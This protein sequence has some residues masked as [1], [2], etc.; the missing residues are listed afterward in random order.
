MFIFFLSFSVHLLHLLSFSLR[1]HRAPP[2]PSR[3]ASSPSTVNLGDVPPPPRRG[4]AVPVASHDA[5]PP[6][7][8]RPS[9]PPSHPAAAAIG[10]DEEAV[11]KCV[12]LLGLISPESLKTGDFCGGDWNIGLVGAAAPPRAGGH[13]FEVG[14][15]GEVNEKGKEAPTR[16]KRPAKGASR[17]NGTVGGGGAARRAP[18]RWRDAGADEQHTM[19]MVRLT[20]VRMLFVRCRG[21]VRHSPEESV[22]DDDVWAAVRKKGKRKEERGR[23]VSKGARLPSF[24]KD[25]D[26][27][28]ELTNVTK[29]SHTSYAKM[30]RQTRVL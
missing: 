26:D 4:R 8:P 22:L 12:S 1:R 19:A 7:P 11:D 23:I 24:A 17:G 9:R 5:L 25:K 18:R 16:E 20:K 6:P 10:E 28:P 30:S 27:Q 21:G 2:W 14:R 3:C 15:G 13:G 29:V